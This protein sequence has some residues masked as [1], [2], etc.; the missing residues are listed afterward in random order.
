LQ[1]FL[2]TSYKFSFTSDNKSICYPVGTSR[3]S[4]AACQ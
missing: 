2:F 4:A 1:F 3:V